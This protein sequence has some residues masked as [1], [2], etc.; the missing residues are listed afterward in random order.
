[1]LL[2]PAFAS[3]KLTLN[4]V[5]NCNAMTLLK[6]LPD[7]SVDCCVTSPPYFG[8]RSYLQDGD[9]NKSAEIGMEPTPQAYV[10]TLVVL[11]RELR[12]VLKD[13][14]TFWLNLG[15]SYV[16]DSPNV[17][18]CL[19]TIVKDSVFF[20]AG[21]ST[22][23]ITTKSSNVTRSNQSLPNEEFTRFFGL[24][25]IGFKE[26]NDNFCQV[27]DF[28]NPD[29]DVLVSSA[30]SF[31]VIDMTYLE[32]VVNDVDNISVV[33][34]DSN[35]CGKPSLRVIAS[36]PTEDMEAPLS[37]KETTKPISESIINA[38]SI[39]NTI[40]LNSLSESSLNIDTMNNPVPFSNSLMLNARYLRDFH[41]IH[42]SEKQFAFSFLSGKVKLTISL[43]S[44]LYASNNF[45]SVIHYSELYDKSN[46]IANSLK[47]KQEMGIPDMVKRALMEDGWICRGTNVW[48]KPN[49]MPESVTDRTTRAH[50]Y[51]FQFAKSGRYYFDKDAIA[52]PA[53]DW[54]T[55]DRTNGKYHNEGTGLQPHSGLK[56][57]PK[58]DQLGSRTYTGFNARWD[59]TESS[60]TRNKR[61]VW[62]IPPAQ[63]REA[64]FATF[65]RELPEIC[66]K[67]GCPRGGVVLDPFMGSG[68]VAIVARELGCQFIGSELNPEY[69]AIANK[70]L[71]VPYTPDMFIMQEIAQSKEE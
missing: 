27:L 46:R 47:P 1:M 31:T 48:S 67:A 22:L 6:A 71:A 62:T 35:D 44:H 10:Q 65:P 9:Y 13:T 25:R 55:R 17:S 21:R 58:Q 32:I 42:A 70:R 63:F 66:I 37:I 8:L 53:Q 68:T 57:I 3:G 34:S 59:N 7:C 36:N 50:E 20:V 60:L 56:G 39:G 24:K 69:V 64:H 49:P 29:C 5:Y 45:G 40:A 14:G 51:V 15:D 11:F 18:D 19:N 4:K 43:V 30:T 54:G 12:R 16:S 26:R 28:L 33:I 52:E 38:Q 41:V 2:L 61:S 23:T